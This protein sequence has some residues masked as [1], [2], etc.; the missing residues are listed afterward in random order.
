MIGSNQPIPIDG[1]ALVRRLNE[2]G[3]REHLVR[4]EQV[5]FDYSRPVNRLVSFSGDGL[6]GQA[7]LTDLHPRDEFF[8]NHAITHVANRLAK[9]P[10]GIERFV[11]GSGQAAVSAVGGSVVR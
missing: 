2:P 1:D 6:T 5:S 7:P 4:G 11:V 8:G 3:V 10:A 9:P